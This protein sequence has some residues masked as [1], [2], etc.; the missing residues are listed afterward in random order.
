LSFQNFVYS[1][2]GQFHEHQLTI[3]AFKQTRSNYCRF[4]LWCLMPLST[5]FQL[6]RG[7]QIY[8]WKETGMP[9]ENHRLLQVTDK[10]SNYYMVIIFNTIN[11]FLP[12]YL[13]DDLYCLSSSIPSKLRLNHIQVV[14]WF[15]TSKSPLCISLSVTASY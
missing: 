9:R 12:I 14:S 5:I 2:F 1:F 3:L 6:Y 11:V 4:G 10:L 15:F 7:S 13:D 8:W